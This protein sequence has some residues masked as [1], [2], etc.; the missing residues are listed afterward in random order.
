[1][2]IKAILF[3]LILVLSCGPAWAVTAV[4]SWA[5]A[6]E[7]DVVKYRLYRSNGSPCTVNSGLRSEIQAPNTQFVDAGIDSTKYYCVTAVDAVGQ[8]SLVSATAIAVFPTT[9]PAQCAQ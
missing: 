8:E 9:A 3:S 4:V 2:T 5:P 6:P 1:M 7:S